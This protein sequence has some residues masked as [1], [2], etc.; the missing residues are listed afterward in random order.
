MK[1]F[2]NKTHFV[3]GR[4]TVRGRFQL[5]DPFATNN[6]SVGGSWNELPCP[7]VIKIG[8]RNWIGRGSM[9]GDKSLGRIDWIMVE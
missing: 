5:I 8:R 6:W 7:I 9:A 2:S 1:A 3:L 4:G